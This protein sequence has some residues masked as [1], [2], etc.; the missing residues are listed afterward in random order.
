MYANINWWC[1]SLPER[2]QNALAAKS[3]WLTMA[4]KWSASF[5][6]MVG[7][8]RDLCSLQMHAI[9]TKCEWQRQQWVKGECEV[10][11]SIKAKTIAATIG[12]TTAAVCFEYLIISFFICLFKQQIVDDFR[13]HFHSHSRLNECVCVN[14]ILYTFEVFCCVEKCLHKHLNISRLWIFCKGESLGI[15]GSIKSSPTGVG[16]AHI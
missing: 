7:R 9:K 12:A 10:V 2:C 13:W 1:G 6:L 14:E 4:C 16:H 8:K 11:Q 5:Q 3:R 15:C